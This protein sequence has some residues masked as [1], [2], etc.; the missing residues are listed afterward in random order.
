ML[1]GGPIYLE[2]GRAQKAA[3]ADDAGAV[4]EMR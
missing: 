3:D 4:Q 2:K 1:A